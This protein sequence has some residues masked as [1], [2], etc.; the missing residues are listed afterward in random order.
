MNG[1]QM[2]ETD[3]C[4]RCRRAVPKGTYCPCSQE[5]AA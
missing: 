5:E 2:S 3:Y 1:G 4:Y